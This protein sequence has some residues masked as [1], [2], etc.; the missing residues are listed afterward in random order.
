[1]ATRREIQDR[2]AS[3]K[4][5]LRGDCLTKLTP[6]TLA[7]SLREMAEQYDVSRT[8]AAQVLQELIEEGLLYTVPRVGTFIGAPVRSTSDDYLLLVPHDEHDPVRQRNAAI[9]AGFEERIA[10]LG[11]SALCLTQARAHAAHAEGVL[12]PLAGVFELEWE[13]ETAPFWAD[14]AQIV[15]RV[16]FRTGSTAQRFD[17][18]SFDDVD[19]GRKAAGH[20]MARGHRRIA[21][22]G[23]HAVKNGQPLWS[24]ERE[25]GWEEALSGA[26]LATHGF[27]FH[28]RRAGESL[29]LEQ[30]KAMAREAIAPLVKLI[31]AGDQPPITAVVA[32]NDTAAQEL[33]QALEAARVPSEHW[34]SLVGFDDN[35]DLAGH[36]MTSLRL[37]WDDLGRAAA[38]VLWKRRHGELEAG[39]HDERVPMKLISRLTCRRDWPQSAAHAALVTVTIG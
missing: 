35:P 16:R 9:C 3:L 38:N 22:V 2:R 29:T 34:P 32:A 13:D 31:K 20:L 6:G 37:P 12:P 39:P 15:Q 36:L 24:R 25:A 10:Q 5:T 4:R 8:V 7:P 33:L 18:V 1:M 26:G 17:T 30:E 27:A 28:P 23:L 14:S 11:G 19:G 21:F